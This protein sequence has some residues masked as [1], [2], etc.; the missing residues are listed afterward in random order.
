MFLVL[1]FRG[2]GV[3]HAP[4][5]VP[6][7]C[8][9]YDAALPPVSGSCLAGSPA[10]HGLPQCPGYGHW[11]FYYCVALVFGSGFRGNPAD[12]GRGLGCVCLGTFFGFI[13]HSWLRFVVRVFRVEF[14]G[15]P[16]IP[17]WRLAC[18]CWGMG[19]GCARHF[20]A[21]VCSACVWVWIFPAPRY[22]W[23]GCWGVCPLARALPVARHPRLGL[24]VA[25]GCVGVAVGGVPPPPSIFFA[26]FLATGGG[27]WVWFSA[28]SC[29]GS[30]V[31]A[32]ACLGFGPLGLCPPL[33]PSFEFLFFLLWPCLCGRW[34]ATS[35]VGVCAGVSGGSFP[36]ALRRLCGRGGPL[37]LAGR[38]RAGRIGPPV[39][40][41]RAPWVS[42]LVL[43]GWGG[44]PP[45]W[46]A[47]AASPLC[48]CPP[49]FPSFPLA[50]GCVLVD[51]WGFPPSAF[52]FVGG[53]FACSSLCLPWAGAR[54][55]Q[56]TVWLT[57]SLLGFWMA[58]GRAPAPWVV[59]AM[60]T[61]GLVAC[62]VRLGSGSAGLAHAPAGCLRSWV[63]GVRVVPCPP[64][65]ALLVWWWRV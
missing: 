41:R 36:L 4:P 20:L 45:L 44:Y 21:E 51:R 64:A 15:R 33:P 60:Y 7:Q 8:R 56:Q 40:Y 14:C 34:P 29:C 31:V 13:R 61:H 5:R 18:V 32:V 53:G 12:P 28:L 16:A 1:V 38:L 24:P 22:S 19:F 62:P 25:R 59:W 9:P 48:A 17:G 26:V 46:R 30:V 23:L 35:P 43:P 37:F 52:F 10:W 39:S 3:S 11:V 58:T 57:G 27:L 63:R 54:T 49:R 47:C 42:P 2:A 6:K 65:P 55:S 50:G